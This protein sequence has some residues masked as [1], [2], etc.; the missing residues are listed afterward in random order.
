MRGWPRGAERT[1]ILASTSPPWT[2]ANDSAG[3]AKFARDIVDACKKVGFVYIV[4]HSV[5][6]A[7]LDQ[8]FDLIECL[9]SCRGEGE[10]AKYEPITQAEYNRMRASVQTSISR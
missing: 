2:K 5:P 8:A 10:P 6:E 4:N 9:P 3:R 1:T 7:L